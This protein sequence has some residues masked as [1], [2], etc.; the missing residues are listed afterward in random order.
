VLRGHGARTTYFHT[1]HG[2]NSRLDA[3]Q[4][5]ILRVKLK[6]LERWNGMRRANT[7]LYNQLLGRIEGIEPMY[8]AGNVLS[9]CNYYTMRISNPRLDRQKLRSHLDARGIQT[10]VYY[11]LSLHLQEV[12]RDL[13]Y[14][15]GDF[16]HSERAQNEVLSLPMYPEL[17]R[18]EIEEVVAEIARFARG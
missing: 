12:Y 10:N 11:P 8:I 13:G 2:F 6:H 4:A 5:A 17:R 18:E 16:P 7:A 14:R 15:P 1:M 3:M 9:S